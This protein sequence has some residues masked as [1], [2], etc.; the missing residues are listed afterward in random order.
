MLG[1]IDFM[2]DWYNECRNRESCDYCRLRDDCRGSMAR[3]E[4]QNIRNIMDILSGLRRYN[5][6]TVHNKS[7][8]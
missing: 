8:S 5:E 6:T 3:L 2:R 1:A 4:P 7:K